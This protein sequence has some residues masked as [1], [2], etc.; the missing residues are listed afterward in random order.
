M[1]SILCNEDAKCWDYRFGGRQ[2]KIWVQST[3]GNILPEN[4]KSTR[5]KTRPRAT[6]STINPTWTKLESNPNIRGGLK[7]NNS[8][9]FSTAF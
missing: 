3:G 1:W 6:L 2:N 7:A 5:K 8:F 9:V 4:D